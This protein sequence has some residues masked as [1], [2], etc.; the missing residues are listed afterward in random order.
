[1][2]S[3]VN[4]RKATPLHI[5][6]KEGNSENVKRLVKHGANV[7][8][9]DE[10]GFTP[11]HHAVNSDSAA[12]VGH[13]LRADS[14]SLSLKG[15]Q[16]AFELAII[17]SQTEIVDIFLDKGFQIDDINNVVLLSAAVR[18]GHLKIV[19]AMLKLGA[20]V[21]ASN[22]E[23]QASLLHLAAGN[24]MHNVAKL[25]IEHKA[26]L[27]AE[28]NG[29][30]TPLHYAV[31]NGDGEMV[32]LLLSHGAILKE[33]GDLLEHSISR[34]FI[35]IVE[36]FLKNGVGVNSRYKNGETP[37]HMA[38]KLPP[39]CMVVEYLLKHGANVHALD[40]N[41]WSPLH[42]AAATS[43]RNPV[44]VMFLL[45]YGADVNLKTRKDWA[46][47]PYGPYDG[48]TALHLAAYSGHVKAIA[49]L[50]KFGADPNITDIKGRTPFLFVEYI[51]NKIVRTKGFCKQTFW[52]ARVIT[53]KE[54]ED[55]WEEVDDY[56]EDSK[57]KDDS[58]SWEDTDTDDEYRDDD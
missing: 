46:K 32:T 3:G 30:K 4:E 49:A 1:M 24:K 33:N 57:S 39:S 17:C 20:D 11:L 45:E 54:Q 55:Y 14:L 23:R 52:E 26:D 43:N 10:H 22:P 7:N 18:N 2:A 19:E 36:I 38:A 34:G 28:D 42:V 13:L 41:G 16:K 56:D 53:D 47:N 58:Y 25:L 29:Q 9:T 8:A 27:N 44:G 12:C 51:Y 50:L 48:S 21:Q 6:A 15:N 35:Q 37:L 40:N 31:Q 5:A